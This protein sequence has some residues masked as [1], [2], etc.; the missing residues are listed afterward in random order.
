MSDALPGS[1]IGAGTVRLVHETDGI[2]AVCLVG[3]FDL[4]NVEVLHEHID[5]ALETGDD[6]I[7]DLSQATFIDSTVIH[8]LFDGADAARAGERTIVLELG[9]DP[10][11]DRALG[12]VR[13][14]RVLP[15]ASSRAEAVQVIQQQRASG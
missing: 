5:R 9:T 7:V 10:L 2:V 13:I 15:R 4:G 1:E 14:E 11:V 6:L 12:L 3:D 8:V